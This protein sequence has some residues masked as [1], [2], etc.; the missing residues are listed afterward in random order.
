[1]SERHD[2]VADGYSITSDLVL[3]NVSTTAVAPAISF[4]HPA[5]NSIAAES[6][7]DV[8]RPA[9]GKGQS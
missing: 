7:V 5:G 1:M 2:H 4:H 3:V 8:S 6:V 9:D